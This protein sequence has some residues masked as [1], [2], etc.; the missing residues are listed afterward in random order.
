M[1][2]IAH[3]HFL[4]HFN[5]SFLIYSYS[6]KTWPIGAWIKEE[7]GINGIEQFVKRKLGADVKFKF[8]EIP[9]RH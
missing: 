2:M 1:K 4:C 5:C 3:N 7:Y 8:S 6:S 9:Y